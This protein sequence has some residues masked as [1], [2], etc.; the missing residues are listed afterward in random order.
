MLYTLFLHIVL[1][2]SLQKKKKKTKYAFGKIMGFFL[3]V[4]PKYRAWDLS[5]LWLSTSVCLLLIIV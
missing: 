1:E 4:V 2:N 3:Y 5:C